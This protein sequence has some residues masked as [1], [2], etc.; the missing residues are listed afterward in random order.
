MHLNVVIDSDRY[1][2]TEWMVVMFLRDIFLSHHSP[3]FFSPFLV[4]MILGLPPLHIVQKNLQQV[5]LDLIHS[6]LSDRDNVDDVSAPQSLQL[7]E[8]SGTGLAVSYP[9]ELDPNLTKLR[10][11]ID[12]SLP[13]SDVHTHLSG[14]HVE[15]LHTRGG[16]FD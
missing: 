8:K 10:S 4:C 1:S 6:P 3:I 14:T 9:N 2:V 13:N 15:S 11:D 7:T 12:T 5:A 16:S